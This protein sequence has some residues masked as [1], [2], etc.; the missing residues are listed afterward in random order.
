VLALT[1]PPQHE[2]TFSIGEGLAHYEQT[3][4]ISPAL[5]PI[6]EVEVVAEQHAVVFAHLGRQQLIALH[7]ELLSALKQTAVGSLRDQRN[8]PRTSFDHATAFRCQSRRGYAIGKEATDE[9]AL[10]LQR[11][12]PQSNIPLGV[13]RFQ[14]VIRPLQHER[15][16]AWTSHELTVGV[17][18]DEGVDKGLS[19]EIQVD[20]G[21]DIR[22]LRLTLLLR[23]ILEVEQTRTTDAIAED[24]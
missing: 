7:V 2:Q 12:Q 21:V 24:D 18:S 23:F 9:Y 11:A 8:K 14:P 6:D 20:V 5:R 3:L 4:V 10:P 1:V 16:F 13:E 19:E 15:V 22:I 17:V